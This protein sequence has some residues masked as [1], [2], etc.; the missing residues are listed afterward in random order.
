MAE[1]EVSPSDRIAS[2]FADLIPVAKT[3]RTADGA[4]LIPVSILEADLNRL[5]LGVAAWTFV[6]Q[7]EEPNGDFEDWSVGYA[8]HQGRWGLLVKFEA[9]NR[10]D[11]GMS[12]DDIWF[13][14]DAPRFIRSKAI[15]GLPKLIEAL[16]KVSRKT[17]ERLNNKVHDAKALQVA[18]RAIAA[19]K[20]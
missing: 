10:R 15:D 13:F 17:A 20:K 5:N 19:E 8:R 16:V 3:L 14:S 2:A 9:G 7:A 1:Q 11:I 4:V 18:V 12:S 6:S